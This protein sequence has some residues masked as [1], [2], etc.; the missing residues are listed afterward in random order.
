MNLETLQSTQ[1]LL[2]TKALNLEGV[3]WIGTPEV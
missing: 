3:E 2:S 1:T